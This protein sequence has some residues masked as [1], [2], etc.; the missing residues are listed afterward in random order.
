MCSFLGFPWDFSVESSHS[1]RYTAMGMFLQ[2]QGSFSPFKHHRPFLCSSVIHYCRYKTIIS[3]ATLY[4]LL[5]FL[6][7]WI[8]MQIF[9]WLVKSYMFF[10]MG[11]SWVSLFTVIVWN[12]NEVCK[13]ACLLLNFY[14][15]PLATCLII[16]S[17]P[18]VL[19]SHFCAYINAILEIHFLNA[20]HTYHFK[21]LLPAF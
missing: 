11:Y 21:L 13:L 14:K 2:Q 8:L 7:I 10:K 20:I 3:L 18:Y 1:K 4:T 19:I 16:T 9:H 15:L 6:S 17:M 12:Y 5:Q